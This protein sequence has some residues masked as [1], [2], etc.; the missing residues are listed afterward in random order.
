M[1]HSPPRATVVLVL[2]RK[3]GQAALGQGAA[4]QGLEVPRAQGQVRNKT[5]AVAL[6]FQDKEGTHIFS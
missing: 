4:R 3:V 1:E 6:C 2:S 5:S